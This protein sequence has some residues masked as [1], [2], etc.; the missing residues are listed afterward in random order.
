M[1]ARR[2]AIP[3]RR[4][5]FLGCEG[6]SEHSYGAL[7]QLLADSLRLHIHIELH[8]LQG[9]DPLAILESVITRLAKQVRNRGPFVARA[10]L[11]DN[12]KY[13]QNQERDARIGPLA[14]KH[15]VLL[16]WQDPCHEGFLLRHLPGC[17]SLRPTT[18]A[19]AFTSLRKHWPEYNKPIAARRLSSRIGLAELALARTVEPDLASLLSLLGFQA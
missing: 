2:S 6:Q 12:D 18:A 11:L 3:Q 10:L 15:N 17:Q 13:G 5:F 4:R 16:I 8:D 9:G 1:R 19:A 7:L 14:Q